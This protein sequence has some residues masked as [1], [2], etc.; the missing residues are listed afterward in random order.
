LVNLIIF[1]VDK[2]D[3]QIKTH[4]STQKSVIAKKSSTNSGVKLRS[5]IENS[6]EFYVDRN[7]FSEGEE[8]VL[9][10]NEKEICQLERNKLIGTV[11]SLMNA[12]EAKES[13]E[14]KNESPQLKKRKESISSTVKLK[15]AQIKDIQKQQEERQEQKKTSD[16]MNTLLLNMLAKSSTLIE[17]SFAATNQTIH[18]VSNSANQN[19][20]PLIIDKTNVD[21]WKERLSNLADCRV[22]AAENL[23][24]EDFEF[25]TEEEQ[26]KILSL[27]S[28]KGKVELRK[29]LK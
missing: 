17:N 15:E 25:L 20:E 9:S 11:S 3:T 21:Y 1:I 8:S 19:N 26:S 5:V 14:E 10:E 23:F 12:D 18:H 27:V 28:F 6:E 16:L 4:V 24:V 29:L 13:I 2:T 22:L 7:D